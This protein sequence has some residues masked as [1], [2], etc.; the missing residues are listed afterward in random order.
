LASKAIGGLY[1]V[2]YTSDY[3]IASEVGFINTDKLY[4]FIRATSRFANCETGSVTVN[5]KDYSDKIINGA[6]T[7][8]YNQNKDA[9]LEINAVKFSEKVYTVSGDITLD[10]YSIDETTIK[11]VSGS[12]S[13]IASADL[14]YSISLPSGNYTVQATNKSGAKYTTTVTVGSSNLNL[15]IPFVGR[16]FQSK[17]T[18]SKKNNLLVFMTC[19][20]VG[21][22]GS[23]W[24]KDPKTGAPKNV[25]GER[26]LPVFPRNL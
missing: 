9:Y 13:Y 8:E 17:Y 26:G 4:L 21:P 23:A 22:D 10:G 16:L 25:G 24:N 7:V 14:S 12:Y 3:E 11:F 20:L 1:S 5:G 19:K 15:N 6:M 2:S 18:V